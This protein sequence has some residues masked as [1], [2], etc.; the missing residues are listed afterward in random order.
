MPKACPRHLQ[1]S[2][3]QNL[4]FASAGAPF[5]FKTITFLSENCN[6]DPGRK[7]RLRVGCVHISLLHVIFAFSFFDLFD[8]LQH[9][10]LFFHWCFDISGF[11]NFSFPNA[12]FVYAKPS[13]WSKALNTSSVFCVFSK[14]QSGALAPTACTFSKTTLTPRRNAYFRCH[15]RH[16][17]ITALS[18]RRRA[19]FACS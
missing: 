4:R 5:C 14:G 3:F 19:H 2:S 16:F 1:N 9:E 17:F 8:H 12:R 11:Q 15:N 10:M 6:S 18:P 13:F 7:R